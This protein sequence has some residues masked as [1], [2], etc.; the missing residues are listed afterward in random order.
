MQNMAITLNYT[1]LEISEIRHWAE[2]FQIVVNTCSQP[3]QQQPQ[4]PQISVAVP[5]PQAP[6][7]LLG[8]QWEEINRLIYVAEQWLAEEPCRVQEGTTYYDTADRS[9]SPCHHSMPNMS[10]VPLDNRQHRHYDSQ[11]HI[12]IYKAIKLSFVCDNLTS[13]IFPTAGIAKRVMMLD[14]HHHE[15]HVFRL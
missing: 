14:G 5:N 12:H 1:Q 9:R 4:V 7:P 13:E 3:K 2:T 10:P 6:A 11:G 15:D 8:E